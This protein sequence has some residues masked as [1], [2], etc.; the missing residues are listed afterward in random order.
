MVAEIL[1]LASYLPLHPHP[2]QYVMGVPA[3]LIRP[4][5]IGH[6]FLLGI[7]P[8]PCPGSPGLRLVLRLGFRF[9]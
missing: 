8:I 9:D 7:F 4:A 6:P 2:S 5:S 1:A 3:R